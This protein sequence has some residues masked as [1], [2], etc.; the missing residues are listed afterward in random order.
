MAFENQDLHGNAPDKA[1]V[2]AGGRGQGGRGK[3]VSDHSAGIWVLATVA[4]SWVEERYHA[5]VQ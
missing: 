3:G 5:M 2:P 1:V 4:I